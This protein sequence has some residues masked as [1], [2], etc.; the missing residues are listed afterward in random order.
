MTDFD[1]KKIESKWQKIW[2]DQ[3]VFEVSDAKDKKKLYVLVEFPY[4]SGDGLHVGHTRSYSA[5]DSY[6]RKKRLEGFN[7]LYPI[8]YDAFGLPTEN[9][10][11]KKG[12]KPQ[13]ITKN[14]TQIFRQQMEAMG[15]S[16]DWSREINTTDPEYYKWT[17]WIFLQFYKHGIVNGKLTKISDD[18]VT[19]PRLAFQSEMSINWC[20][21]CKIGL[22]NE[23]VV[24]G[25][26]ERC[27]GP[28][29][30]KMQKQW[31]LRITA[32][33]DRLIDDLETVDYPESV[34]TSQINWIG[35]SEG[36]SI[37]FDINDF[38]EQIEVY[39]TR[40]DTL[41][42]C[43]WVVLAPEHEL[44]EKLKSKISNYNEVESYI[45]LSGKKSDLERTELQK[46]KTGVELRGV[47]AINPI[48][49]KEVAVWVADYVLGHYGTGAV[50]AVPAHDERDFEFAKKYNIEIIQSIAPKVTYFKTPPKDDLEYVE[51]KSVEVIVRDPKTNKY[52]CLDWKTQPWTTFITGGVDDGETHLEAA[53]REVLEETGYK[54]IKL[55]K[56]L[57]RTRPVFHAAHKNEN[58]IADMEG[59]LF[60]LFDDERQD[61]SDEEKKI[62]DVVWLDR[63]ELTIERMVCA[64]YCI[65]MSGID[66]KEKSIEDYG[67]LVNSSDFDGLDSETAKKR[68]TEKLKE[69][70]HGD[71]KVNYKLRD[72]IFSRQHYWGE[73]IPLIHCPKCG[74][75]PVSDDQLPVKLPEVENYQPTNTGESPLANI[76]DWVNVDCPKCGS[77]AKRETDTM[78][79]WA[80]SSWYF[81]RYLDP[82]NNEEFASK[83]K[84]DFWMPVDVYNGGMEHTTLHLLYSRFWYK[85]LFDLGLVPGAEPYKKRISHGMILGADHQKMS[86]S[87]GNVINPDAIVEKYSADT[88]RTY[89]LFIGPYNEAATWNSS[90]IGGVDRFLKRFWQL[91]QF[92]RDD[93]TIETTRLVNQTIK[94]I[95]DDLDTFHFNTVVS[96]LMEISNS[97]NKE[98]KITEK[99]LVK[100]IQL[101]Y[102][103]A[104]HISSEM[105]KNLTGSEITKS[106]WP[107]YDKEMIANEKI[108]IAVQIN[109]KVRDQIEIMPDESQENVKKIVSES[110]KLKTWIPESGIKKFIYVKGKIVSLVV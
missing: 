100:V 84:M 77:P 47:K 14:N 82:L 59:F 69:S 37:I 55:V 80:G 36:S 109:G 56:S 102:P 31:M 61:M 75:I 18:D 1:P 107:S 90:S 22:A 26:C 88:L 65:W 103:I 97:I 46:E 60:E 6:A 48:N 17:Q 72:W 41:F 38:R 45:E 74:I 27:K 19:N 110:E 13:E 53:K 49:G 16:F 34:A 15:F 5:L 99:S 51:R 30:K 98:K 21:S 7:V 23:E 10:A 28:I 35:R 105:Y 29:E 93:E 58:R 3:K 50:M 8:G 63:D 73:P 62:H 101:L 54:N 79:N 92:V 95:S 57:G 4:P 25:S 24:A 42:G 66:N 108:T 32:Y 44:I 70:G 9:T 43:T 91:P 64:S 67:F 85:F 106:S 20:P 39:T 12:K 104:P 78:P 89:I 87:F 52:L 94:K 86:K 96:S 33:A 83:E 68:I 71:F 81:L 76:S 11:I 2:I 40:A